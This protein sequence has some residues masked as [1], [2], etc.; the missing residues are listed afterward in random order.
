MKIAHF[1]KQKVGE[2][3]ATEMLK[4]ALYGDMLGCF[5]C[6]ALYA[7]KKCVV[8]LRTYFFSS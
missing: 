1:Q 5:V 8:G 7:N 6:T 4:L 2:I 3:T